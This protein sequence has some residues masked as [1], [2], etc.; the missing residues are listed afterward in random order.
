ML[1]VLSFILA[2]IES[3]LLSCTEG[4]LVNVLTA[5]CLFLMCASSNIN[6]LNAEL[7]PIC[8]LL[9]FFGAHPILHVSKIRVNYTE[10]G[11]GQG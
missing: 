10:N 7:N 11:G 8:H 6:P 4:T 5:Q 2:A 9:A 3:R 1:S